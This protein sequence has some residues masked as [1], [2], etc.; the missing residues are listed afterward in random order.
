M[1]RLVE[2]K[3]LLEGGNFI[4]KETPSKM[5]ICEF[6]KIFKN[7]FWQNTSGWLPLVFICESHHLFYRARLGNWLFHVQVAEFQPPDTVKKYFTSAFK[8]F[9]TRTGSSYL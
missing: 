7:I 9:Y 8:A 2:W 3:R 6:R 1:Q 4:K 5:F